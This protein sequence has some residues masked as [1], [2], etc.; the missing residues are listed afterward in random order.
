MRDSAAESSHKTRWEVWRRRIRRTVYISVLVAL[1]IR[2]I[3]FFALGPV[4]SK[5]AA[6]Y[7]FTA[8]YDRQELTLLGGDVG[9]W[10][11]RIAPATGGPV[12]FEA[13]YLRGNVSPLALLEGRLY[14][15][16]AE[17]DGADLVLE[18]T[19][20]GRIPLL[21]HLVSSTTAPAATPAAAPS[22]P[23]TLDFSPSL[24]VEAF[25]L[26][27]VRTRVQDDMVQPAFNATVATDVRISNFGIAGQQT[28]FEVDTWSD[29]TLD[30]MRITGKSH[31]DGQT[32]TADATVTM[33][34]LHPR[35]LIGYL[36]PLGI[37]PVGSNL[38]G[39][40]SVQLAIQPAAS[41]DVGMSISLGVQNLGIWTDEQAAASVGN[42]A[43]SAN[44]VDPRHILL[45]SLA[46]DA[47]RVNVTRDPTTG[48][49]FAGFS[50][51]APENAG[52]A[53]RPVTASA[54]SSAQ[55][56]G[57]ALRQVSISDVD[58]GFRDTAVYPINEIHLSIPNLSAQ[59]AGS[60]GVAPI[61]GTIAIPGILH[62]ITLSGQAKAGS[63][64]LTLNVRA[65]GIK[66][67]GLKP[68][69]TA[70]GIDSMW[71]SGT[72]SADLS[73]DLR[74]D[75]QGDLV[76]DASCGA[77]S[78]GQGNDL[79]NMKSVAVRGLGIDSHSG[80]IK[81]E[82]VELTGPDVLIDRDSAGRVTVAN[83]RWTPGAATAAP[84]APA[85]P[86]APFAPIGL[87][88]FEIGRFLWSEPRIEF[89]DAF[90]QP[91]SDIVLSDAGIDVKNLRY[92]LDADS[93]AED[94]TILAWLKWPNPAG[95][96]TATGTTHSVRDQ[97]HV[98][99]AVR[100]G[101]L[102]L[103]QLAPFTRTIGIDPTIQ[104]GTFQLDATADVDRVADRVGA[105][106]D[107]NNISLRDGTT[108]LAGLDDLNVEG[109]HEDRR[110]FDVDR[111]AIA[112]PRISAGRDADGVL[113]VAGIRLLPSPPAASSDDTAA[114]SSLSIPKPI[115]LSELK[116]S[117]ATLNWS[118]QSTATPVKAVL[119]TDVGIQ[120]I[121]RDPSAPAAK[122]TINSKI[123]GV[124]DSLAIVGSLDPDPANPQLAVQVN[125][126]GVRGGVFGAYLPPGAVW[127]IKDGRF[128]VAME[129][130]APLNPAGGRAVNVN[131]HDLDWR[132]GP[133]GAPMLTM[134]SAKIVAPRIDPAAGV[135]A[136]DTI[137][138]TGLKT[139]AQLGG[140]GG[141][142][143]MGITLNGGASSPA[144]AA[145]AIPTRP[146]VPTS[147]PAILANL[148]ANPNRTV[149]HVTLTT[150][151]INL[152][153]IALRNLA[154]PNA[155]PLALEN[156][157]LWN[158][159]PLDMGGQ[160]PY[161]TP[162]PIQLT[163]AITPVVGKFV[164]NFTATP[165]QQQPTI[166]ADL[167]VSGIRGQGVTEVAPQFADR[168]DG[169][170]MTDG[171]IVGSLRTTI[172][173]SRRGPRD[174]DLARG[175]TAD[176]SIRTLEMRDRPD[177]PVLAGLQAIYAQGVSVHPKAGTLAVKDLEIMTPEAYVYRDAGG[178]HVCGIA[179][180][181]AATPAPQ[182][183]PVPRAKR[184]VTMAAAT[185][186][187][188]DPPPSPS[189]GEVRVDRLIVSGLD[190][191]G[192]D[193][194]ANPVFV[195]PLNGLDLEIHDLTTRAFSEAKTIRFSALLSAGKVPIYSAG[196]ASTGPVDQ[197]SLFS[198]ATAAGRVSLYPQPDG[199]AKLSLNGLE[200][201]ALRWVANEAG[202]QLRGGAFDADVQLRPRDN[203]TIDTDCRLVLTDLQISEPANGPISR[204]LK[205]PAPLDVVIGALQSPDGSITI[206]V[207]F[208][209]KNGQITK[210][211]I[212]GAVVQATGPII[213]TAVASAP[214]KLA[215]GV[216]GIFGIGG[217]QKQP[218]TQTYDIDFVPGSTDISSDGL[219][220]LRA[221]IA[222]AHR[223]PDLQF[224]IRHELGTGDV[225]LASQRANPAAAD[226]L[227]M[228]QQLRQRRQEL[229][230]DRA[231]LAGLL[232]GELAALSDADS[233]QTVGQLRQTEQQLAEIDDACDDL[234]DLLRPGASRQ[235]GR[236]TRGAA[237][238]I[239]GERLDNVK[240]MF[241]AGLASYSQRVRAVAPTFNPGTAEDGRI[242]IT[243]VYGR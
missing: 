191:K 156:V 172:D 35:T 118:D 103:A 216:V 77:V 1:I 65:D 38:T 140:N 15:R 214:L 209:I 6:A 132:D 102:R 39:S 59:F 32:L 30:L 99:I 52:A 98:G 51:C 225:Q 110:G 211:A 33:R 174:F 137:S 50:L 184:A 196:G 173:F 107:I 234:Y 57:L 106:L 130:S 160:T 31:A 155:T 43:I 29:P 168:L 223:N 84:P 23:F 27:Y 215:G 70:G 139:E 112:T 220:M 179:I 9:L 228:I 28:S 89:H 49:Q 221:L 22:G 153:R 190:V 117:D 164:V 183:A 69:L 115:G 25:R 147:A 45:N 101:G 66:P 100:G 46:L 195:A 19:A 204:L 58:L 149:P 157:R 111:I 226:A 163:G 213:A 18:R 97:F 109:V 175:F 200:L 16:R 55:P 4:L 127:S 119:E 146:T 237:L 189:K 170:G 227:A 218:R 44:A 199:Y 108:E 125:A 62:N 8:T 134:S 72:A 161:S 202:V 176:T 169:T 165:F 167:S 20:D 61:S 5:V 91:V 105:A 145:K 54:P 242:R 232:R 187:A 148:I 80:R 238:E 233:E 83:F 71:V 243:V 7:G 21:E 171:R 201:A 87:P 88:R 86:P 85:G 96:L 12:V 193:R 74:R 142:R 104:D 133:S 114:A 3:L 129:A 222:Q 90:A 235:A 131:V 159:K 78:I 37:R 120:G 81:V 17:V 150:L 75:D 138:L 154:Q 177:G 136:M 48:V 64:Q 79:I 178:V 208:P 124:M 95:Q 93:P 73:A 121:S 203:G 229:S 143:V 40:L 24:A 53:T 14:V 26:Q 186:P 13:D 219:A 240:D 217:P 67:D 194:L 198:Q 113:R 241:R 185:A 207:S 141:L 60:P 152:E 158:P 116:I 210:A 76:A 2:I 10:G 230:A 192:E 36:T 197:R 94:G 42:F 63:R 92:D 126:S 188:A 41:P 151:D 206:P 82:S 182:P 135:I 236:R 224:N 122:F 11:L 34:G 47:V 56:F 128:K 123:G 231:R 180:H 181:A 144:P 205:L 68:Y 166:T 212:T 239:A 162:V